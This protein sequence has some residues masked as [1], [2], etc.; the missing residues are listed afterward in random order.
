MAGYNRLTS[1]LLLLLPS[2]VC[3]CLDL[4]VWLSRCFVCLIVLFC[5]LEICLWRV[6]ILSFEHQWCLSAPTAVMWTDHA[7]VWSGTGR[8]VASD[9]RNVQGSACCILLYVGG[10]TISGRNKSDSDAWMPSQPAPATL[11]WLHTCNSHFREQLRASLS[12]RT[13]AVT[14]SSVS[15]QCCDSLNKKSVTPPFLSDK[16]RE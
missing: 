3:M 11:K 6:S 12:L 4:Y 5:P 2:T 1:R 10:G 8:L 13:T 14:R 16:K 15:E 7:V 9:G